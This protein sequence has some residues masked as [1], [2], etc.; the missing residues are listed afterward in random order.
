MIRSKPFPFTFRGAPA[1]LRVV[2]NDGYCWGEIVVGQPGAPR[3]RYAREAQKH[4][5]ILR[6]GRHFLSVSRSPDSATDA[7]FD[8]AMQIMVAAL[9]EHQVTNREAYSVDAPGDYYEA[10]DEEAAEAFIEASKDEKLIASSLLDL[11][12]PCTMM[13][14]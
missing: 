14:V 5:N 3:P 9:N 2:R 1:E 7:E 10:T 13:G 4:W 12:A 8:T 11:W 6:D